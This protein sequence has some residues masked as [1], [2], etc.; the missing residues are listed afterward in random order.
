MGY[1]E[2]CAATS[3]KA[4]SFE[5]TSSERQMNLAEEIFYRHQEKNVSIVVIT[6]N[7]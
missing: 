7:L 3:S 4:S 6:Y 5:V 1:E 2:H